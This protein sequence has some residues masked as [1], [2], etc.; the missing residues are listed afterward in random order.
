MIGQMIIM[1][2]RGE[3][4]DS[5]DARAIAGWLRAGLIGGVIFFEDNLPSP[6]QAKRFTD[7]FRDAA[8]PSIPFLCVDQEGGIVRACAQTMAFNLYH[9]RYRRE[10]LAGSCR[11]AL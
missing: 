7:L 5:P 9:P 8:A 6:E 4:T 11:A 10:D 2:F 1:G 3:S